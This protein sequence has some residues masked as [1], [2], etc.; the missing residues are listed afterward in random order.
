MASPKSKL[1]EEMVY[2]RL[3]AAMDPEPI[4]SLGL[5]LDRGLARLTEDGVFPDAD[6][7]DVKLALIRRALARL[8][9]AICDLA[10]ARCPLA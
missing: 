10:T 3:F 4:I 6:P 2:E 7:E 8:D 5:E 9:E 1:L